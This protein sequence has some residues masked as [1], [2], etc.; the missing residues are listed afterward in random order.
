MQQVVA[1]LRVAQK[2]LGARCG[3]AH[4][5]ARALRRR[6]DQ[7]ELGI[8]RSP[9]AEAAAHVRHD[10]MQ[11]LGIDAEHARED[12]AHAV[13]G[14]APEGQGPGFIPGVVACDGGA[15][16]QE[17]RGDAVVREGQIHHMRGGRERGAGRLAVAVLPIEGDVAGDVV[18]HRRVRSARLL[19]GD[20]RRQRL[21]LDGD[22]LGCVLRC[23]LGLGDDDGHRLARVP[24]LGRCE[25][26]LAWIGHRRAVA[27]Q[28]RERCG[29][30]QGRHRTQLPLHVL[31][32]EHGEY[33]V[34]RTGLRDIDIEDPRM[35][36][37]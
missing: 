36:I 24:R 4:G 11:S 33:A 29:S 18:P 8:R 15:G 7:G 3:P 22:R 26:R 20:H 14:L 2:A 32:G 17:H 16:L 9:R 13:R 28:P 34:H 27:V 35:R 21:V 19:V 1:R 25:G 6:E 37:R 5:S 10:D 31:S 23:R 30:S 12:R